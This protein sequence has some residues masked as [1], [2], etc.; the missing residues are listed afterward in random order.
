MVAGVS[1]VSELSTYNKTDRKTADELWEK[2]LK[3]VED[4]YAGWVSTM[5]GD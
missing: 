3:N 4:K 5:K 1:Y 2:I